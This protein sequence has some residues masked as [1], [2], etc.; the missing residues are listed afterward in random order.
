[1]STE[2]LRK[3]I[4]RDGDVSK[5]QQWSGSWQADVEAYVQRLAKDGLI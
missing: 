5:L 4:A 2:K 3:E 1:M